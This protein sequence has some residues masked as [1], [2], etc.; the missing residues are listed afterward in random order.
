MNLTVVPSR[1]K[2]T[3]A[4]RYVL[5]EQVGFV[6]RQVYQRH[7]M[8]FSETMGGALTHTQ[9]AVISKLAEIGPCSQN[10]LGRHTAM[11][12]A[13]VKGVVDRLLK[14]GLVLTEPDPNDGRRILVALTE[15]GE[16]IADL[17]AARALDVSEATLAPLSQDERNQLMTLL[18]KLR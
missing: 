12:A 9:W 8:L 7:T 6:L 10:L 5:N 11:D 18:A 3:R 14:R 4:P 2:G 17:N 13:T 1:L 16:H 15:D